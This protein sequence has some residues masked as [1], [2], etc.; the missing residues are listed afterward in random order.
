MLWSADSF[1]LVV[2]CLS[3]ITS[4]EGNRE[5]ERNDE[6]S[7]KIAYPNDFLISQ[8]HL[9]HHPHHYH[10]TPSYH[11]HMT[12][13]DFHL[14]DDEKEEEETKPTYSE[15]EGEEYSN[16]SQFIIIW[17]NTEL[18]H[19]SSKKKRNGNTSTDSE[20]LTGSPKRGRKIL[21]TFDNY[22]VS[23]RKLTKRIPVSFARNL[24]QYEVNDL[25]LNF[26]EEGPFVRSRFGDEE[27][28]ARNAATIPK[29]AGCIPEART[30]SLAKS[31]DPSILYIPQ[32]TRIERCGGCCSHALLSCQPKE[33]ETLSYQVMKTQ[34]TG[35]K[36]LKYLGKEIVVVEKHV[37]CKC[38]CK[39]KE[40]DCNK[41]QEYKESECRCACTNIDE[42]K[43]C[44][45]NAKKL[46]NPELCACQCRDVLQ[47]TTG[48]TF[49]QIECRCVPIPMRRRFADYDRR[50]YVSRVD[51]KLLIDDTN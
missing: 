28:G 17:I 22:A 26:V 36:K 41:Y 9:H 43:K 42:E 18:N 15:E 13:H 29:A 49:D 21:Q 30:V 20:G 6:A 23:L 19:I 46:W 47:C 38:D 51:T 34:Y 32:C 2:F 11:G 10:D 5:R 25:L 24:N 3:W 50:G 7:G 16:S 35:A 48:N 33:I 27:D 1:V 40:E 4:D 14:I 44:Y 37:S 12:F 8:Q 39:V 45:K 31:D